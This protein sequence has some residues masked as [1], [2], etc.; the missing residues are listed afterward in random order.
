MK[1]NLYSHKI[2]SPGKA[3]GL[4]ARQRQY[5][6]AKKELIQIDGYY[7]VGTNAFPIQWLFTTEGANMAGMQQV[8]SFPRERVETPGQLEEDFKPVIRVIYTP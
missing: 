2:I 5:I 4:I 3:E 1:K 8:L 7:G 6:E